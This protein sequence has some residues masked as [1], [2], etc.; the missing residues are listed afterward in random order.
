MPSSSLLLL[1]SETSSANLIAATLVKIGHEVTTVVEPDEAIRQAADHALVIV[2]RVTGPRSAIDVCREIRSSQDL[3]AI[4]VLCISQTDD[5]EERIRF[6]EAGA[7]DVMAKPFDERELEARVEALLLRFQRTKGLSPVVSPVLTAT[8]KGRIVAVFSPKGGVGTTTIAVNLAMA[9][10]TSKPDRVCLLDL[11]LQ[12]GQA[13]THLNVEVR[14]SLVEAVRDEAA[15]REAELLRTYATRHDSGLH[16]LAAPPAPEFADAVSADHVA[17]ILGII[18]DT[19]DTVV[20]DAG[21]VL[22]ERTMTALERADTVVLPVHP[23]MAA[24][25]AVHSLLDYLNETGS[26]GAKTLFV[27]NTMFAREVLRL[28]D[29]ESALGTKISAELPYDPFL[30]LKAVNEG[31]P[32]VVG[33]PRSAPAE[34]LQR[35]ATTVFGSEAEAPKAPAA[36]R[37][38]RGFGL[39]RRT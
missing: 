25:R 4:P 29:V 22:D 24:L 10:A 33:A 36:E 14:Q 32:I 9:R 38:S 27:L 18:L 30:Y 17:A 31:V 8:G 3:A 19:Y 1:D 11:D 20:I 6:L 13:A 12:F 15:L 23:E 5:V 35:L 39:L 7:D 21:S 37:R 16:L 26:I 34:R 28:R 2:D